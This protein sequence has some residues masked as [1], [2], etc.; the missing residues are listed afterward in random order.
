MG[1]FKQKK[2]RKSGTPLKWFVIISIVVAVIA[3]VLGVRGGVVDFIEHYFTYKD[4][5]YRP[6]DIGHPANDIV[7]KSAK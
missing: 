2:K 4:N 7:Q 3:A 6:V 1:L 5:S